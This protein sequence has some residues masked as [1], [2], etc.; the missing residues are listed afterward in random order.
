MI[1][2][3]HARRIR[4]RLPIASLALAWHAVDLGHSGDSNAYL[5]PG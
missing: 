5:A 2:M 3:G 4:R 1:A